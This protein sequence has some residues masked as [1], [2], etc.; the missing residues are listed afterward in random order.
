MSLPDAPLTSLEQALTGTEEGRWIH[1]RG[2]VRKVIEV[3]RTLEFQM[4]APGGE[5]TARA[6]RD[7]TLRT[8]QGSVIL[9]RGRL[10]GRCECPPAIDGRRS[11]VAVG[12]KHPGRTICA[13]RFVCS[14][15]AAPRQ[16]AAV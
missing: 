4:V 11:L 6:P 15:P 13:G 16:P 7:S 2:Y 8:L 10:C 3:D 9:V 1:M 12:R 5:F 14:A